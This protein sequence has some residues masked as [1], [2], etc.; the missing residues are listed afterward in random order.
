MSLLKKRFDKKLLNFQTHIKDV[1]LLRSVEGD[2]AVGL[3]ELSDHL[4]SH[5]RALQTMATK[6]QIADGILIYVASSKMDKETRMKWEEDLAID[7]FPAWTSMSTFLEKRCRMLENLDNY[8]VGNQQS[9]KKIQPKSRH[10]HVFAA[11][12][13]ALWN[14]SDSADHYINSYSFLLIFLPL[15]DTRKPRG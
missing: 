12:T 15:L 1:F 4:N 14:F 11:S 6:E 2:S 9:N 3:R 10:V 7:E 8:V 5:L 13:T